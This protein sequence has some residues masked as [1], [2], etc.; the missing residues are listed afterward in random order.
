[1]NHFVGQLL[2][3]CFNCSHYVTVK[4]TE[5]LKLQVS[6]SKGIIYSLN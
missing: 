1:M 5:M 6:D 3:I 4:S 2:R